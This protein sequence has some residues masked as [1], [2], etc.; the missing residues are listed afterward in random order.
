MLPLLLLATYLMVYVVIIPLGIVGLVQFTRTTLLLI[1][2]TALMTGGL[3]TIDSHCN[4]LYITE[5]F[6]PTIPGRNVVMLI[7]SLVGPGNTVNAYILQLYSVNGVS[8]VIVTVVPLTPIYVHKIYWRSTQYVVA[9]Y[10]YT[11][12]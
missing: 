9:L 4:K 11:T 6:T 8:I 3:G 5:C 1:L 7:G 2:T 10:I 12:I